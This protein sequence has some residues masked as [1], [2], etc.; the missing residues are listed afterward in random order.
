MLQKVVSRPQSAIYTKNKVPKLSTYIDMVL[1]DVLRV[2]G[3]ALEPWSAVEER[4]T[5]I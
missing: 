2:A 3:S 4:G 5:P 1:G